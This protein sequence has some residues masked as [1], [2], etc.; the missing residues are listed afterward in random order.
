MGCSCAC[1]RAIIDRESLN[2]QVDE[3]LE[4]IPKHPKEDQPE[5]RMVDNMAWRRSLGEKAERT[6]TAE[7]VLDYPLAMCQPIVTMSRSLLCAER[8]STI[9]PGSRKRRIL[10]TGKS[11]FV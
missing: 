10:S 5:S 2:R 3:E 6:Q 4:H 7:D 11:S 1:G 9:G 8:T